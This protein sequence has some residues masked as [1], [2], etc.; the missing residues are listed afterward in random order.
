MNLK[1]FL[2]PDWKKIVLFLVILIF[3]PISVYRGSCALPPASC[4]GLLSLLNLFM[5]YTP[6]YAGIVS[7]PF[8]IFG[9]IIS[10]LISCLIFWIYHKLRKK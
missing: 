6:F 1:E 10:Y 7:Y 4:P 3:F 2:R 8:F 5:M 9:I